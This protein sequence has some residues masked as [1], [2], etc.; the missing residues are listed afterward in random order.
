MQQ[1][2]RKRKKRRMRLPA[3]L[4]SVHQINDGRNRRKPWRARVQAS[5]DYDPVTGRVKKK[6]ITIGCFET[7]ADAIEALMSYRK[8]P[9]TMEAASC[10]FAE[11]YEMWSAKKFPDVSPAS[12][13]SYSAAYNNSAKLHNMRVRDIRAVHLDDVMQNAGGG[14]SQQSLLKTLWKQMFKYAM[15][16][17]IIEK[18]YADFVR[19]K[20][21][22]EPTTRTAIPPEDREKIWKAIDAGD[23]DAG[24]A[25]IYIYT[26]LRASELLAIKKR[27]VDLEARIMVGG[28]KTAAGLNRRIPIH[29]AILPIIAERMEEPGDYLITR[30]DNN[31]KIEYTRFA[32]Y[33]WNPLMQ[34]LGMT[35]YTPHF[36]RH[37]CATMMREANMPEDIRKLILGHSTGDITDRYTHISDK[38]L[39]EAMDTLP[40]R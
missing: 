17:D 8:A 39:V 1:Q 37:T 2:T 6:Y 20:D 3:G 26:G 24:T 28:M 7:E 4:G 9:F 27:D 40:G 34:R 23:P 5:V 30:Y 18:N 25:M 22:A 29:P 10:T 38:M 13:R 31:E 32:K 14:R 36:T 35:Q 15:E 16:N 11:L 19:P 33:H 12:K 21:K